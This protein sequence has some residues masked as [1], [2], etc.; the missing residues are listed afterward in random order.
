M[1]SAQRPKKPVFIAQ[2]LKSRYSYIAVFFCIYCLS[3]R[4]LPP[5]RYSLIWLRW[6]R[7]F[8]IR[9]AA[10]SSEIICRRS[11][12]THNM[13]MLF[14]LPRTR[15]KQQLSLRNVRARVVAVQYVVLVWFCKCIVVIRAQIIVFSGRSTE[16]ASKENSKIYITYGAKK[17]S[18]FQFY[19]KGKNI[20]VC[21]VSTLM[22]RD[23]SDLW[24]RRRNLLAALGDTLLELLSSVFLA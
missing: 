19:V 10:S 16:V 9:C 22:P 2:I 18:A 21:F 7:A 3:C 8:N 14:F 11:A 1:A 4:V 24:M 15:C 17:P 5:W 6:P 12:G 23:F 20:P 13:M